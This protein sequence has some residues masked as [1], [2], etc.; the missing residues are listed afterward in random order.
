MSWRHV[1]EGD[2]GILT[3]VSAF[4]GVGGLYRL[5]AADGGYD[6]S[7]TSGAAENA[8]IESESRMS[9]E[10]W[11]R[12][13]VIEL[14]EITHQQWLYRNVVV[15]DRTAGDLVSRRKE[16]IREALEEQMELGEEGLAE[17]DRFLLEINLDKLDN[18]TGEHQ[19]YWLLS[20]QAAR[21]ARK[22]RMQ[23]N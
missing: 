19:T 22:M 23:Q 1:N 7:G 16:E 17:E 15:H 3:A 20:L 6:F 5:E 4:G 2:S 14:L 8:V 21:E 13:L 12:E 9:V 10:T 18:S 11:A